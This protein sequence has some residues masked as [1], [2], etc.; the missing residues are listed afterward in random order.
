MPRDPLPPPAR[1]PV[2]LARLRLPLMW[3]GTL[4]LAFGGFAGVSWWVRGPVF[5]VGLAVYL[6]LGLVRG[7]PRVVEPPVRGRWTALASPA[8]RV[9]SQGMHAY[10]QSYALA[11]LADPADSTRPDIGWR[12]LS[13]APEEFPGFGAP[14][15]APVEGV[16][17]RAVDHMR[18]HRSR[19]SWPWLFAMVVETAVRELGGTS[20]LLGNH[21][22]I[23][24]GDGAFAMLAHLRRGSLRVREGDRVSVG[25]EVAAC[26]N[27]GSSPEPQVHFQ[28]M[29]HPRAWL[30]AGL[31]FRWPSAAA[32]PLSGGDLPET[33]VP[34]DVGDPE[35]RG[36]GVGETGRANAAGGG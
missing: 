30:A 8:D 32:T 3:S 29:D 9:P 7:T 19:T 26:G 28:L 34:F 36:Y 27:S 35:S 15:Y 21:V 17:V 31:P 20:G 5:L 24:L 14:V 4:L 16:V 2:L 22:V 25:Q 33:W 18:D 12:P 23:D 1:L 13:R 10:G 6:R 11:L